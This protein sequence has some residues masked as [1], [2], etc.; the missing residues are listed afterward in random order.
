[1]SSE[2]SIRDFTSDD[3]V[4]VRMLVS[5]HKP[6]ASW[7]LYNSIVLPWLTLGF[8]LSEAQRFESGSQGMKISMKINEIFPE[9]LLASIRHF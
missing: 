9:I 5:D 1:M 7:L 4:F 3:L 8:L 6:W 2:T